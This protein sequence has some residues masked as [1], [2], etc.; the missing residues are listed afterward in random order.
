MKLLHVAPA[1]TRHAG[2]LTHSASVVHSLGRHSPPRHTSEV[3]HEVALHTQCVPPHAGVAPPQA[4]HA[5]PQCAG[6]SIARHA[7]LHQRWFTPHGPSALDASAAVAS[8]P[9][10][11]PA[12]LHWRVGTS[13]TGHLGSWHGVASLQ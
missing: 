1:V 7:P 10:S 6:L 8:T 5:S 12:S 4:T 13:H 11:T 2:G 9:A 3:G